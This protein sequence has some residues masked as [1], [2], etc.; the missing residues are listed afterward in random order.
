[1]ANSPAMPT[2]TARL[3]RKT[4][5]RRARSAAA[6]AAAARKAARR[7]AE[8]ALDRFLRYARIDTQSAE[9]VEAVPSTAKQLVLARL[10]AKELGAMGASR[11]RLDRHGYV[12]A[13]IPSNLPKGHP[14]RGKVPA[15]GLVAHLDTSPA[16]PGAGVKPQVITYQGGDV[17]LPG[18]PSVV[19]RAS[20]NPDLARQLGKRIVTSDGTTLL[21][22]DDKAGVAIVM[23]LAAELL[24]P[25][26]PPHG[27][28]R[29]A[30]TPDEEVG[31]G[32]AHFDLA[33]FGAEVAY[34]V[35]GDEAGELNRETFSAD[36]AV[37]KV[38][39]RNIHPGLAKGV[40]VNALRA[41]ADVIVRL[42]RDMAPETTAGREPFI[43]PHGASGEEAEATLKLLFRDFDTAGLARQRA[44]VE[45]ILEEVRP[46]HPGARLE[47]TVT[48]TYR[49]MGEGVAKEP[50][51][52]AA[53]EEAARRAG[54]EPRWVPIRGGTDGSRLTAMGLPCPNVFTGG[55][56]F[57]GKTEWL[58]V[59]GME[60][61]LSTLRHLLQVWVE[62]S[63][64]EAAA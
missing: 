12:M 20:E 38:H 23:A 34:T 14:A 39:G 59:D 1:M 26:A 33:A 54:Q 46:L 16:A 43:H 64:A 52:T 19:I 40:M 8:S 49:N 22:A 2:R 44:I 27:E 4:R 3:S 18:D 53:L 50:R 32:T 41:L 6:R 36:A 21:G 51:V 55:H 47:L 28:V 17:T 31:K 48:E 37:V 45:R 11:V 25:G 42:P 60:A 7:A 57:H 5:L 63:A 15:V 29:I 30:F 58:A 24:A 10:L 35:D 62:L 13:A 9:D 61:S 56:N